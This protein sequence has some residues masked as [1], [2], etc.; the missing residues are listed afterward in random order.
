MLGLTGGIGTGK[1]TVASLLASRGIPVIDADV[2]ARQAVAP[3]TRGLSK[4]VSEFGAEV[5]KGDGSLNRPKLGAIIFNDEAK[6]KKLNG[7]V[8]PAVR[9]AMVWDVLMCWIRGK[10][11]CV[12]DIP[13]LIEVGLWKWMGWVVVV[14][15]SEEVQLV[16]LMARDGST[17]EEASSRLNSQLPVSQK[18]SYADH[19]LDNSGTLENTEEQVTSLIKHM[20]KQVTWLWWLQWIIPPIG[21]LSAAGTLASRAVRRNSR[22]KAA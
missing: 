1:S 16:R 13:L 22:R 7:I 4:I 15:C 21:F 3:G 2:L 14:Y 17:E 6:R 5:L 10:K 18:R 11:M 20:E 8:H 19:I 12:L 9:R